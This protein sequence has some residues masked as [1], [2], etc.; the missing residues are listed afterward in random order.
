MRM[1]EKIFNLDAYTTRRQTLRNHATQPEKTL[2]ARLRKEQLGVKFRRQH[3]IGHYIVDFYCPQCRLVVE[4]DG[5][6]HF[7]AEGKNYDKVRDIYMLSL[8]L[9]ILR[10]ANSEVMH[11]LEGVYNT[12]K[13]AIDEK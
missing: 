13:R 8:G 7:T 12:I 4:L 2:W 10:F 1:S 9:R 5:E 11:N 3:G 6:S